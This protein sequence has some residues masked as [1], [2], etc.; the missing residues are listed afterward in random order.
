MRARALTNG[1]GGSNRVGVQL[2]QLQQQRHQARRAVLESERRR[3]IAARGA[4]RAVRL[5]R[6]GRAA[7]VARARGLPRRVGLL[8]LARPARLPLPL[9]RLAMAP[10]LALPGPVLLA[11]LLLLLLGDCRGRALPAVHSGAAD[12]RRQL[13]SLLLL[14]L[15]F[16]QVLQLLRSCGQARLRPMVWRFCSQRAPPLPAL[17]LG[18]R[19]ARSAAGAALCAALKRLPLLLL[20]RGNGRQRWPGDALT[21]LALVALLLRLCG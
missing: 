5:A 14:L 16:G 15:L 2:L 10:A 13:N 4:I 18:R 6:R 12:R 17:L 20:L 9:C 11:L 3:P 1:G 8:V 19:G 7:A 21:L